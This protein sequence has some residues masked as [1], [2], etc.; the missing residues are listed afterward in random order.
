MREDLRGHRPQTE[1]HDNVGAGEFASGASGNVFHGVMAHVL[2][3]PH[4]LVEAAEGDARVGIGA[5]DGVAVRG[6][7]RGEAAEAIGE[8]VRVVEQQ[9]LCHAS[10]V[11]LV[12]G[13]ALGEGSVGHKKTPRGGGGT[14]ERRARGLGG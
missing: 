2:R 4:A 5:V 12:S 7:P 1:A 3:V 10:S 9:N 8:A 13:R 6:E 11:T 14:K